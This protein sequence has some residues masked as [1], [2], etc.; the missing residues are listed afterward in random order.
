MTNLWQQASFDWAYALGKPTAQG[1]I[2]LAP[3]DFRVT[4]LTEVEPAGSGEH[5]WLWIEKNKASTDEVAKKLAKL[6]KVRTMDVGYAGRK[7]FLA[8]TKQWFSVWLPNKLEPDW[9]QLDDTTVS[10]LQASRHTRKLK[11]G[12]HQGNRFRITVRNL[13]DPDH[14]LPSRLEQVANQGVPNY[15]GLQRFGRE[16]S[17]LGKAV[18]LAEGGNLRIGRKQ[19]GMLLSSAR[20]FLFNQCLSE[21][22]KDGSWSSLKMGEP[23]MLDGSSAYFL[24]ESNSVDLSSRLEAGDIHPSAPLLGRIDPQSDFRAKTWYQ[25]EQ[26]ILKKHDS[27]GR[28]LIEWGLEHQRRAT[29][30]LP[31][32][33]QSA[34]NTERLTLD[35]ELGKGQFATSVLRELLRANG[36]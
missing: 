29:R 1:S 33:L 21:R 25:K 3:D 5:V 31:N 22:V 13:S 34:L 9:A 27:L 26:E 14:Q 4:E 16:F 6:A 23:L 12:A 8:R 15:F 30:C 7:D 36:L 17:N 10:V 20:S 35:F 2:K 24:A 11:L 32:D 28:W 19:R 18:H